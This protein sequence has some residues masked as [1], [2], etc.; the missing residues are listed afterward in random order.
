MK[1]TSFDGQHVAELTPEVLRLLVDVTIS[2]S[3]YSD[4]GETYPTL[5]LT[6]HENSYLPESPILTPTTASSASGQMTNRPGSIL[7]LRFDSEKG[8]TYVSKSEMESGITRNKRTQQSVT[9]PVI[10]LFQGNNKIEI[11]WGLLEPVKKSRVRNFTISTLSVSGGGSG[12]GTVNITALDGT[13]LAK[14]TSIDKGKLYVHPDTKQS[15]SLKQVLFTVAKV[16]DCELEFDGAPVTS[17]PPSTSEFIARRTAIGGDT[18][19]VDP[20]API[21]QPSQLSMH[22]FIKKLANEYSSSYEFDTDPKTKRS[23]L[24]FQYRE[25]RYENVDRVFT[26]RSQNDVVLNYKIDSVEGSFNPVTGASSTVDGGEENAIR[27][28]E[29]LAIDDIRLNGKQTKSP[30]K[31]ISPYNPADKSRVKD[32]LDRNLVNS[33]ETTP[34]KGANAV[35]YHASALYNKAKYNSTIGLTTL[36]DPDYKPGLIQ[37]ENIGLRYSKKYR[38][39]TVQH[40]LGNSGYTCTWSGLSHYAAEGGVDADEAAKD[41]EMFTTRLARPN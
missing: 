7:D 1:I 25:K 3:S 41:N 38:M 2:E 28:T 9:Q 6:F 39:F 10:F 19:P 23:V 36:G 35:S 30:D 31:V 5:T 20:K 26:Y 13:H 32:N 40:K 29:R 18:A 4:A 21:I 12:N 33:N 8:F 34:A 16:L 15:Y 37:M 22:E 11:E 27:V 14:K 17:F 24:K